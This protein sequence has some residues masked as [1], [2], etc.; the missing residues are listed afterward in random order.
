MNLEQ[1]LRGHAEATKATKADACRRNGGPAD[2]A[3]MLIWVGQD[4]KASIALIDAKGNTMD[5]MPQALALVGKQNPRI[6]IYMTE[7]YATS[8][9]SIE[10]YDEFA[11]THKHGDLEKAFSK[12]GPL[13]GV[14]ELIALSGIDVE[15]GRQMQA[16]TRFGYD[17]KGQPQFEETNVHEVEPENIERAN[18]SFVFDAFHEFMKQAKAETN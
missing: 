6:V 3:P 7:G 1:Q 16:V 11:K 17:D 13:S 9:K 18:V 14:T 4:G 15:T 2:L 8:V 10:E 12:L 5:Y